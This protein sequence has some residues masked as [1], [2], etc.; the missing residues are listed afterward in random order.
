MSWI[1][2]GIKAT[3]VG[4]GNQGGVTV[5]GIV[6]VLILDER[7]FVYAVEIRGNPT[8][9]H[10]SEQ[11]G[12]VYGGVIW[13]GNVIGMASPEQLSGMPVVIV[14]FVSFGDIVVLIVIK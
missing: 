13:V 6:V 7:A 12:T 4:S 2:A 10:Q 9:L 8:I 3:D 1:V 11:V 5:P 14:I